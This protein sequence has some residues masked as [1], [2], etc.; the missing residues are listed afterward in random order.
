MPKEQL[1]VFPFIPDKVSSKKFCVHEYGDFPSSHE[2]DDLIL[3]M[4]EHQECDYYYYHQLKGPVDA[5]LSAAAKAG[6]ILM[7]ES[8]RR[9]YKHPNFRKDYIHIEPIKPVSS[10]QEELRQH[11]QEYWQTTLKLSATTK[12]SLDTKR[13]IQLE[14]E[15]RRIQKHAKYRFDAF[16]SYSTS[17]SAEAELVFSKAKAAGLRIFMAP[18]QL[19]P[20]DDFAEEIRSSLEGSSELWLLLSPQSARS[21]WVITEWGAAWVLRRPIIPIL[22]RCDVSLL[23]ERLGRFQCL[24][25]HRIDEL[26]NGRASAQRNVREAATGLGR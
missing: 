14:E 5:P 9:Y 17:N 2:V 15:F 23:P 6:A 1:P 26:I 20:G 22:H 25:L 11:G 12:E 24:D 21:E 13:K 8:E 19:Q 10:W 18:K 16:L 3:R 4:W 7:N